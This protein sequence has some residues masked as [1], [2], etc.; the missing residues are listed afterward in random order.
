MWHKLLL[1][2]TLLPGHF[3][4]QSLEGDLFLEI[5]GKPQNSEG[6]QK[7]I[8]AYQLQAIHQ[9]YGSPTQYIQVLGDPVSSVGL[10]GTGSTKSGFTGG[11]PLGLKFSMTKAQAEALLANTTTFQNGGAAAYPRIYFFYERGKKVELSYSAEGFLTYV[12]LENKD[13]LSLYDYWVSTGAQ[14]LLKPEDLVYFKNSTGYSHRVTESETD[15]PFVSSNEKKLFTLLREL[16]SHLVNE[17]YE[18]SWKVQGPIWLRQ[19]VGEEPSM[20]QRGILRSLSDLEAQIKREYFEEKW[21]WKGPPWQAECKALQMDERVAALLIELESN[22][23]WSAVDADWAA[24]REGWLA[25]CAAIHTT[26]DPDWNGEDEFDRFF[27]KD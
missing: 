7:V 8:A 11:L 24:R 4:A 23:S 26:S 10:G 17:A 12:A 5:L 3:F 15:V 1:I 6:M 19:A 16:Q 14:G 27:K 20:L 25:E 9:G 22:L 21:S 13:Y 2:F 18:P